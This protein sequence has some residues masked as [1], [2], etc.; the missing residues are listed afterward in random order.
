MPDSDD[1]ALLTEAARAAGEIA[2]RF[3]RKDHAS[4]D[5]AAGAGPVTEADLAVDQMLKERLLAARPGYGWLSEETPDS[6][7]RLERYRVFIIDPIDGTRAF[8]DGTPDFAHSLAIAEA[9]Q[10]VAAVVFLPAQNRL[11]SAWKDGPATLNGEVLT[12]S[13][14]AEITGAT[15]LTARPN[16]APDHWQGGS[17]PPV[18]REFRSSLAWRMCLVAEGRFD[19]MLTLRPTWE[20]DVAAGTL[21]AR[22]AGAKVTDR[23]GNLP[24]FN[25]PSARLDGLLS[26]PPALHAALLGRLAH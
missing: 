10:I 3:W 25:N 12:C 6:A 24:R 15:L 21:I 19:A 20:W 26:A 14:R 2:L 13:S 1:L 7:E 23:C 9:G 18:R 16:L 4:W 5:K 8:M 11:Y 17:P 22:R